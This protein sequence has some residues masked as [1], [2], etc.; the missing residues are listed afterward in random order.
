MPFA[1]DTDLPPD[2]FALA[3]RVQHRRAPVLFWSASSSAAYLACDPA[4]FA[5]GLDPEPEL[6][7]SACEFGEI[8]RWFGLLPY[9]ARRGLE[10]SSA[11]DRRPAPSLLD[12][13]WRRYE[14]VIEITNKVRIIGDSFQVIDE[15]HAALKIEPQSSAVASARLHSPIEPAHVHEQRVRRAL[16]SIARGDIY[17]VNLARALELEVTGS[18]FELLRALTQGGLPPHAGAFE[19]PELRVASASP[20]LLLSLSPEGRASTSPIKGTRP[21]SLDPELD[22]AA[23]LELDADP[24]ERAELAMVIDVE[25]ND[26]GRVARPGSV[27]LSRAPEVV[28]LPS[29]HHRVATVTADILPP[30]DRTRLLESLLP[31]GSVTGAPKIRAMELIAELEAA[32]RGLYTGGFGI[33]RRDGGLELSMAI[34]TLTAKGSRGQYFTGGG[35]VADSIPEREVEETLWKA[36]GVLDMLGSV[37][38]N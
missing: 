15:L 22:R 24:K 33:L 9:E 8:P 31:S 20:E 25:R 19:W 26:L 32:R 17:E 4:A 12:A 7:L 27:V 10:R 28:S 5:S 13:S 14:T 21:R 23:A 1:L 35:I 36:R 6:S 34:R 30:F 3:A 38:E 2:A 16:E 18:A 11:R 29:V 37:A